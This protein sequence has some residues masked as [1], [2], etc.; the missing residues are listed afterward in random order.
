SYVDWMKRGV[1]ELPSDLVPA[2]VPAPKF[3]TNNPYYMFRVAQLSGG[4][5]FDPE[6]LGVDLQV[7]G[8]F[9]Y[10]FAAHKQTFTANKKQAKGGYV[11]FL[12][13]N[14]E[15]A[16]DW[17]VGAD[18]QYVQAQAV[19]DFDVSGISRGN[20]NGS[21]ATIVTASSAATADGNANYQGF[22]VNGM[23]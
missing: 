21:D 12:F 3:M 5:F 23:F 20:V 16:G 13:G 10:N 11:G 4:Y 8:A 14:V 2:P 7:F 17:A 1:T 19:P 22:E 6:M 15:K 9:L 18:Y